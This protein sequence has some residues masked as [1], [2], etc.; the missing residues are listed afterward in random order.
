[1]GIRS[2]QP[3]TVSRKNEMMALRHQTCMLGLGVQLVVHAASQCFLGFALAS[4]A[5]VQPSREV[6]LRP[7]A[8]DSASG[9]TAPAMA[10]EEV[11]V[12]AVEA[13]TADH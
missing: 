9:V 11:A 5:M 2:S 12:A 7:H 10:G 13:E 6:I 3:T 1:M 4:P 8:L